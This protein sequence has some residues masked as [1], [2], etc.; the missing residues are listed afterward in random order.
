MSEEKNT[1]GEYSNLVLKELER[2]NDNYD[3]MR[4]DMDTRFN[5]LNQKL[6]EFKN[7][8][9]KVITNSAWIER[10][11]DV[12]SPSQMKEA[13]DEI[14]KQKTRWAA[15]IAIITFLQ[16]AIGIGLALWKK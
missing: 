11:N 6:T 8:E 7:V 9:G 12:W 13:K 16:I 2:L 14:Y 1:W 15:A 10:V 3:K 5:E 4:T